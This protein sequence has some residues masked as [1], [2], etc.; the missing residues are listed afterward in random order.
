MGVNLLVPIFSKEGMRNL[1]DNT[2]NCPYCGYHHMHLL[3]MKVV[4]GKKG[5]AIRFILECEAGECL[6]SEL[7][8]EEH[9]GCVYIYWEKE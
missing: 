4:K 5:D 6:N 2:L 9:K 7:V 1:G 8:V 3:K